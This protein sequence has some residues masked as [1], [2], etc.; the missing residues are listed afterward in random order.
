MAKKRPFPPMEEMRRTLNIRDLPDDGRPCF[1]ANICL[2]PLD[3]GE[4]VQIEWIHK[5]IQKL[6]KAG[7]DAEFRKWS[8]GES[9]GEVSVF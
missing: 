2:M 4:Y 9:N 8:I 3:V 1:D 7:H 6:S 5:D